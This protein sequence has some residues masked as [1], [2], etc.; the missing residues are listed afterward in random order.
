MLRCGTNEP[1][2]RVGLAERLLGL[3]CLA[4]ALPFAVVAGWVARQVSP[5]PFLYR[6]RRSGQNGE[7]FV[8][9]KLRTMH[10]GSDRVSDITSGTDPRIFAWGAW[11]RRLKLDEVP[12]LWNV[13][14]GEMSFVG[15]RP[16]S[17]AVVADSYEPWMWETLG[18][19]P[20]IVGPGSLAYFQDEHELPADPVEAAARYRQQVLPRK[21]ARELVYVRRRNAAYRAELLVRTVAGI[22]GF[23][24]LTAAWREREEQR[25]DEILASMSRAT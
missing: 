7:E 14:R 18:V 3:V 17:P 8:M 16:E 11:M 13:F 19:P 2:A 21:L 6:A 10:V 12:Q 1:P 9:L 20:G 4:V 15:P 25:A 24:A 5:G 23:D 22:V